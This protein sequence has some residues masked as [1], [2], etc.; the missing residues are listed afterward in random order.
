MSK[1]QFRKK[2]Q[3]TVKKKTRILAISIII[4]SN[5]MV[6]RRCA[7]S[8]VSIPSA[9]RVLQFLHLYLLFYYQFSV[10]IDILVIFPQMRYRQEV[11]AEK[12]ERSE[13]A[14]KRQ[15]LQR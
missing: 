4:I 12:Q 1:S 13:A 9:N 7:V 3:Q 14:C 5:L 6:D 15:V 8:I 10:G 2:T 11:L